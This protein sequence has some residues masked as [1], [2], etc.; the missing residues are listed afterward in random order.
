MSAKN[1]LKNLIRLERDVS[2]VFRNDLECNCGEGNRLL[3]DKVL[4]LRK[5]IAKFSKAG[6]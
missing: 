4:K 1:R 5:I 6:K 3:R 2:Q